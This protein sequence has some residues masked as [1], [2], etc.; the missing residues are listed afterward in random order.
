MGVCSE[1]SWWKDA[2]YEGL[3]FGGWWGEC[4]LAEA[5]GEVQ[6]H[7][8]SRA[9]AQCGHGRAKLE[10]RHDFGCVQWEAKP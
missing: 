6:M 10:T 5:C 9:V 4:A 8:D 3:Y 7:P 1:C 2:G